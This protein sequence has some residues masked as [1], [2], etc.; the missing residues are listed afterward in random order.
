MEAIGY[1]AM[2]VGNHE[3]DDGPEGL[4]KF[5]DAVSFPVVSGNLDLSQEPLLK[6]HVKDSVI[7]DIG[8]QKIGIV[9]ALATDT[10]DTSSPGDNVKFMDE[11]AALKEDVAKMEANGINKIIA[12]THVGLPMDIE[13]AKSVP[14]IDLVIGGHSHTKL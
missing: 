8:G 9:S 6:N 5:I 1:D 4:A 7:I 10:V 14:G 3:F 13:I 2:A 11:I 12:L